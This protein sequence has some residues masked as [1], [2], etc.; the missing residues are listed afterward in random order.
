MSGQN[1][2][3]T[4]ELLE[5]IA[6][7]SARLSQIRPGVGALVWCPRRWR[8]PSAH[9]G[10]T[11]KGCKSREKM[12]V[13]QFTNE[14]LRQRNNIVSIIRAANTESRQTEAIDALQNTVERQAQTIESNQER[15]KSLQD[16]KEVILQY[17]YALYQCPM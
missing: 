16:T 13:D 17:L 1:V 11:I 6:D 7:L 4:N 5:E 9:K 2:T 10:G 14:L 12:P 15:L 8:P 3:T